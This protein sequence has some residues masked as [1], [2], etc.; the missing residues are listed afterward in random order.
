[1]ALQK[2]KYRSATNRSRGGGLTTM[3][4]SS[5]PKDYSKQVRSHHGSSTDEAQEKL[6][7]QIKR[8]KTY[9]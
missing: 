2:K 4:R 7:N 5:T 3:V 6:A 8:R 1:M 9:G